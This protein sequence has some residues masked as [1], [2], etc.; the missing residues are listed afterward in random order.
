M[1]DAGAQSFPEQR[2][3]RRPAV[4]SPRDDAVSDASSIRLSYLICATPRS[5]SNFLCEVLRGTAI[6]GRPDDY[7]WNPPYWWQ[8]WGT[9]D[10]PSYFGRLLR[11]GTTTN[12][13]FG[14]KMMWDYLGDLLPRLA[15]LFG[16]E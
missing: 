14:S 10:F 6:A 16:V 2:A 3:T 12:G 11:E 4:Q 7:F 15:A 8:R 1:R 9:A 5:G 13:V